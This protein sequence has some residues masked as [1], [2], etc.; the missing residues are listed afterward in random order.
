MP[1]AKQLL[2]DQTAGAFAGRADMPLMAAL[3]GVTD[4]EFS[5]QP[6]RNT[7]SIEHLVRHV[8]WAKSVYCREA[9]STPM[10]IDDPDVNADGDHASLPNEFPC[11]AAYGR[12]AVPGIAGAIE[13]LRRAHRTLTECLESLSDDALDR[14]LATR[15]GKSAAN[16]FWIMV[17]HDLYH[18][19]Q[20]RTRRTLYNLAC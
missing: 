3:D 11:G 9:F 13:L 4:G 5:W 14:P 10:P 2:I 20:I 1:T 6:D 18:A 15:H 16:F 8:A 17:M 12:A 7:P 19:G